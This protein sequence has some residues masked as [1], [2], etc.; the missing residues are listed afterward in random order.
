MS[1]NQ[2]A[3]LDKMTERARDRVIADKEAFYADL[4]TWILGLPYETEQAFERFYGDCA[5][6]G[7]DDLIK[8]AWADLPPELNRR[9]E[10][11]H[12]QMQKLG[13]DTG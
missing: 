1:K 11:I 13:R 9:G 7:D 6:S 2:K 5:V 12:A 8:L 10:R 4:A 3:R